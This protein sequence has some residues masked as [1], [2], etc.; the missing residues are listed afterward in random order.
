MMVAAR[1]LAEI[2]ANRQTQIVTVQPLPRL[3]PGRR[4][5]HPDARL[6]L[7]RR[8]RRPAGCCSTAP[9]SAGAPSRSAATRRR[10]GWPG[11]K[12]Q[13]HTMYLYALSGLTGGHRRGDDAGPHH[14]GLV[15]PRPALRARRHRRRRR[16]RH[17][18]HRRARHHRRHRPRRPH[19]HHADQRLHPEQPVHL[20]A[21]AWPRARSSSPPCCSSSASP[22]RAERAGRR[23]RP[24]PAV[25]APPSAPTAPSG[26]ARSPLHPRPPSQGEKSC[27]HRTTLRRRHAPRRSLVGRGRPGR[28]LHLEHP[29]PTET[30]GGGSAAPAPAG[31]QRRAG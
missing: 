13:R 28:R 17:P 11:I 14:R 18:A 25:S 22:R 12:V 15:H 8:R 1:G 5:R 7:R 6:D 9:P 24:P 29:A 23:R 31:R 26:A 3:L 21:V 20:R 27:P 4:P 19:L 10:P 30:S 2:I 16:R